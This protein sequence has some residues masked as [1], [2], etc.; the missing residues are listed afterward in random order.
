MA[1]AR[2]ASTSYRVG[3]VMRRAIL[4]TI[5]VTGTSGKTT[6][7]HYLGEIFEKRRLY[8][9]TCHHAG[10]GI[11]GKLTSTNRSRVHW[12]GTSS[13]AMRKGRCRLYVVIEVSAYDL[14]AHLPTQCPSNVVL[15]WYRA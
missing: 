3:M 4:K 7:V 6:T 12:V 13:S 14:D 11:N 8:D 10:V 2:R 15:D 5:A 9:G 1:T